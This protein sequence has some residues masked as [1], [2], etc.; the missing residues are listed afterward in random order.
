MKTKRRVAQ[1]GCDCPRA[2]SRITARDDQGRVV[3]RQRL[4][5][6]DRVKLREQL[7]SWPKGTPVILEGTFGWGWLSDEMLAAGLEPHLA[8]SAKMAAW[9]KARGLAKSDRIDADLLSELWSQQPRWWEVWLAPRE[10]QDQREWLRYRMSLVKI[11][12]ALKNRTHAVLHRHG[13]I[14][15]F[16]DLFGASGRRYLSLLIV[17]KD[18]PLPESG[19]VTLKGYLQLLGHL[20]RQIASATQSFR[21]QVHRSPAARRLKTLP[22]ISWILSYTILAEVGQIERFR[23]VKHL[24]AYSLLAPRAHDSGHEEEHQEAPQGRHVGYVG[25]RTL[26]WAWIE[27]AHG[28]VR[29]GGRFAEIFARRTNGGKRD[30]NRGYIAVA[31]ELCR[32]A[33]VLWKKEVSYN[34]ASSARP[35][36]RKKAK[37]KSVKKTK[38]QRSRPGKGQ[39]DHPMVAVVV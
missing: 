11:Q 3:W 35:G 16:S 37:K 10:V 20:R 12:T 2:F 30:R 15:G 21:G 5:H 34:P 14:H 33:Y 23:S 38:P 6:A 36:S 28:A 13:V 27:A 24:C 9:R 7:G 17:A 18:A 25:R 31:H 22:G 32:I 29:K 19:R 26:K 39:P 8:S 4:E 1:V